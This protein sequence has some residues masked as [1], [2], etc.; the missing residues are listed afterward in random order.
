MF[1]TSPIMNPEELEPS[2]SPASALSLSNIKKGMRHNVEKIQEL[3]EE[4]AQ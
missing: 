2:P 3:Q 4:L 1:D